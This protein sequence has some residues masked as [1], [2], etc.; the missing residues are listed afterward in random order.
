VR[1]PAEF[2]DDSGCA[3]TAD[4]RSLTCVAPS[5]PVGEFTGFVLPVE[6]AE[7]AG[8][9]RVF[10]GGTAVASDASS[11]SL[12]SA[13]RPRT[14]NIF[15]PA[16]DAQAAAVAG[17]VDSSDNS[18][19]FA[20]LTT[21]RSADL[22]VAVPTV[23]AAKGST[24]AVRYTVRNDG[25]DSVEFPGV[26]VTA[27][28]GTE[29]GSLPDECEPAESRDT[30]WCFV[31]ETLGVRQSATQTVSLRVTGTTVG[32]DGSL[33]VSS[34]EEWDPARA[35][36]TARIVMETPAAPLTQGRLPV[37][38]TTLGLVGSAGLLMLL[39]GAALALGARRR[40]TA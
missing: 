12:R 33:V 18:D 7:N 16:T 40:R 4:R 17:D 28:T 13:S 20:V 26:L 39:S 15:E 22:S 37:T 6:V 2:V 29:F 8:L 11:M 23:E 25:P 10:A 24:V 14:S 21:E 3:V 31:P 34:S 35:D 38:G 19:T 9:G 32:T 36:N 27:P 5:I 1:V 30:M